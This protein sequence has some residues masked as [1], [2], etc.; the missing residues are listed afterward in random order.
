[1]AESDQAVAT[2]SKDSPAANFKSRN[3]F[4]T[5]EVS[6][7][8]SDYLSD[9]DSVS[10]GAEESDNVQDEH[11]ESQRPT[12]THRS[13]TRSACSRSCDRSVVDDS[14]HDHDQSTVF[15][16]ELTLANN[17]L[18]EARESLGIVQRFMLKKGLIDSSMTQDEVMEQLVCDAESD[19]EHDSRDGENARQSRKKKSRRTRQESAGKEC[20]PDHDKQLNLQSPCETTICWRAVPCKQTSSNNKRKNSSDHDDEIYFKRRNSDSLTEGLI[21]MSDEIKDSDDNDLNFLAEPKRYRQS[22]SRSK[23]Q[24]CER[25]SKSSSVS[26]SPNPDHHRS[27]SPHEQDRKHK[28]HRSRSGSRKRSRG[29]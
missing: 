25:A 21:D 6:G 24:G 13:A 1:M 7:N 18:K 27:A 5:T 17:Q 10:D 14:D 20:L 9:V 26:R 19:S 8:I 11:D 2:R 4:V 23:S 29:R 16:D 28:H 22:P 3:N 12:S 15:E